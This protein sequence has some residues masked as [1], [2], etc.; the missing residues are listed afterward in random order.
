MNAKK[1]IVLTV[2]FGLFAISSAN[3]HA[4]MHRQAGFAPQASTSRSFAGTR[5]GNWNGGNWGG[6]WH[7]HHHDNNTI[8][9]SSFGFPFFGFGYPYGYGYGYAAT[10]PTVATTPPLTTAVATTV[11][12]ITVAAAT[13][14]ADITVAAIM[15]HAVILVPVTVAI[16]MVP[17]TATNQAWRACSNNSLALVT[18]EAPSMELWGLALATPCVPTSTIMAQGPM[19]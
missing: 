2:A 16:P 14:T 15:E 6:N 3:V 8:F 11:A 12:A 9:I 10:I 4:Q 1:L 13:T 7:H 17:A 18:I 19:G 5:T